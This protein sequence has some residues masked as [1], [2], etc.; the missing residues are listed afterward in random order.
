MLEPIPKEAYG[1]YDA[2]VKLL[3][4]FDALCPELASM[5]PAIM[6]PILLCGLLAIA[7]PALHA[8]E[9]SLIRG[10]LENTGI[11]P[12]ASGSVRSIF[13]P[14]YAALWANLRGL[15]PSGAYQLTVDG[16][17]EADF[18]ANESGAACV[19]F[20]VNDAETPLDFDPRG[21]E[22]AVTDG[23]G[24]VLSMIYAGEG[25][26]ASLYQ[27][28]RT[29]LLPGETVT[30]GRVEARYVDQKNKTRFI[31][32]LLALDRGIYTVRVAGVDKATVDL[33]R[34]RSAQVV[35]EANKFSALKGGN[36][37]GHGNGNDHGNGGN[38]NGGG[39]GKSHKNRYTLDFDPRGELVEIVAADGSV[40][41][42]GEIKANIPALPVDEDEGDTITLTSTGVDVDATGEATIV[43]DEA[44]ETT[45]TV[46]VTALPVGDYEVWVGNALRAT[47]TVADDGA[48]G[49]SGQ[50]VFA[51]LTTGTEVPLDFPL[52]GNLE[53]KQAGT[54]FLT[55]SL[56]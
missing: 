19:D 44:G 40:A 34:G 21:K 25:E 10:P 22:I 16:N 33:S 37:N 39:K 42:S 4:L 47:L 12:D 28:E 48:G 50:I 24:V 29:S 35:F 53:I 38:G 26:P 30:S 56:D 17:V 3:H 36:G 15:T 9:L 20:R 18:T 41:F 27:D 6:K 51:T 32:H 55:A 7:A 11:D 46:S 13:K 5:G 52:A 2:A 14:N 23:T 1:N 45:L 8:V 49:T 31:L 43:T 54:I